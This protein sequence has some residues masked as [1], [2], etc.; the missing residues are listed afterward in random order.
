[1]EFY[2]SFLHPSPFLFWCSLLD[3]LSGNLL[4]LAQFYVN[5]LPPEC[6]NSVSP[7]LGTSPEAVIYW[8]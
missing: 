3:I 5:Y 8:L 6:A 4:D 7:G 2:F 1:M